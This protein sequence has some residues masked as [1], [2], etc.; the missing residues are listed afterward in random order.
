MT[1]TEF[2]K[3]VLAS[4]PV[5]G[6][7]SVA[8]YYSDLLENAKSKDEYDWLMPKF[9]TAFDAFDAAVVEVMNK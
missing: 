5:A 8:K 3:N 7:R 9:L 6:L 1:K 4:E 2:E